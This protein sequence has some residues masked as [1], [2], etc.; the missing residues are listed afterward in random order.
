MFAT[1]TTSDVIEK[2]KLSDASCQAK[3]TKGRKMRVLQKC[4]FFLSAKVKMVFID[5][6]PDISS[7]R[8]CHSLICFCILRYQ[9]IGSFL[10]FLMFLESLLLTLQPSNYF[11]IMVVSLKFLKVRSSF[12]L[13]IVYLFALLKSYLGCLIWTYFRV[14]KFTNTNQTRLKSSCPSCSNSIFF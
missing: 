13:R 10:L 8:C 5:Y 6:L 11:F 9:K 3:K 7:A 12:H 4:D 2:S 14:Q 1:L